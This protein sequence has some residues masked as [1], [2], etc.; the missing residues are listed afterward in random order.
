[1]EILLWIGLALLAAT[2]VGVHICADRLGQILQ[3][4][5][6]VRVKQFENHSDIETST[7]LA[8]IYL[9]DIA[10]AIEKS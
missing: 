5:E 7:H 2:A 1:M 10:K 6:R 3:S 9:Q 8:N 4:L